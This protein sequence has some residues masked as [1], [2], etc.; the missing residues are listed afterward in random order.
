MLKPGNTVNRLI[1]STIV[2]G[3][4]FFAYTYRWTGNDGKKHETI[5]NSDGRGHY[6]YL[7][8][9][10]I[11]GYGANRQ[12]DNAIHIKHENSFVNKYY[13]G[14]A[15]SQLPFFTAAYLYCNITGDPL[16]GFSAPFQIAISLAALFYFFAALYFLYKLLV[17]H[18]KILPH[19]AAF[20]LLVFSFGSTILHYAVVAPAFS[21]V[22]TFF[23]IAFFFWQVSKI[24]RG[25][26]SQ[27][28]FIYCLFALSMVFVIRPV[29]ILVV[30]FIPVFF[31]SWAGMRS[32]FKSNFACNRNY[33]FIGAAVALLPVLAQCLAWYAQTGSFIIWSYKHEGFNWTSPQFANFLFSY[34]K[35]LFIYTPLL[36]VA[37][38]GFYFLYKANK[39]KFTWALISLAVIIYVLCSWWC[40][41]YAGGFGMR[42]MTDFLFIFM[43]LFAFILQNIYRPIAKIGIKLLVAF[44][45]FLNLVFTY[46]FY[47]DIINPFSM[48]KQK[49]W[50]VFLKTGDAYRNCFGGMKD[51]PPYAPNGLDTLLVKKFSFDDKVNGVL[52]TKGLEFPFEIAK[53]IDA[54]KSSSHHVIVRMKRRVIDAGDDISLAIVADNG[55]P[56]ALFFAQYI[57]LKE[58]CMEKQGEWIQSEYK[59]TLFN[60]ELYNR[61][62]GI[63]LYNPQKREI[64]VDDLSVEVYK[65]K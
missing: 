44:T 42:P 41:H 50:S 37:V 38:V 62:A 12:F 8:H 13:A 4:L 57:L 28:V 6:D 31:D 14:T 15:I 32:C 55:W 49:F 9:F 40:W 39:W 5:I 35:G 36:L 22:Y 64:E 2:I 51:E 61:N 10:F 43:I 34:R 27:M 48:D 25:Q 18:F 24:S 52:N 29:N 26:Y 56:A 30:L 3:Y 33:I 63:Y 21:H 16:T 20:V 53:A 54:G 60:G 58:S 59:L 65:V 11:Y 1:F 19:N 7:P 23:W 17:V 47:A 45:V 46:Q